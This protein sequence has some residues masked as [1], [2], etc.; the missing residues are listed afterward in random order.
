MTKPHE[1]VL[2]TARNPFGARSYVYTIVTPDMGASL[3]FY[4]D[5]MGYACIGQGIVGVD[6]PTIAGTSVAGRAWVLLRHDEDVV[7]ERGVIRLLEAP[8]S[9]AENRPRPTTPTMDP[10][11]AIIECHPHDWQ[12]AYRAMVRHGVEVISPPQHY[13]GGAGD[14]PRTWN[15]SWS[16]FGPAGEQIFV[17][18][19]PDR[20]KRYTGLYGPLAASSLMCRDRW[21]LWDFYDQVF[22]LKAWC[23]IYLGG[24]TLNFM[25]VNTMTGAPQG[26]F[27]QFGMMGDDVTME[28]WE[29][30]Q[31]PPTALPPWPT[32]L[33]RTGLAMTTMIVDDLEVIADRAS[34]A[35]VSFAEGR[36]L[37]DPDATDRA[38]LY[39]SG[40][41]G[42][43][44][45]VVGR[46]QTD[47]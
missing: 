25:S 28:W 44:I 43:L 31:W 4:R 15:M 35:G 39:V 21:P 22:G 17:S 36:S 19:H 9:A 26:T 2:P 11:L 30:R 7:S 16:C 37:P 41:V 12:T 47:G 3:A 20:P 38:A 42:E 1:Q 18:A 5:V 34:S 29:Y 33:D 24:E 6:V 8:A 32:S 27:M 13:Y 45:E 40:A 14:A 23:D 10:G 46:K